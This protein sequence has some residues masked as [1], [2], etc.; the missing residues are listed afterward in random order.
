MEY[1]L[2]NIYR[3]HTFQV[4]SKQLL[5]IGIVWV[6]FAFHLLFS[7]F[8]QSAVL[9]SKSWLFNQKK[10]KKKKKKEK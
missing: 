1:K 9:S 10:K 7:T 4:S 5:Q 6:L 2:Q 8:L 3:E